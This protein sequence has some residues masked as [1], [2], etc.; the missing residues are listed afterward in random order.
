MTGWAAID[1]DGRIDAPSGCPMPNFYW[2][3]KD[4]IID[5]E[6]IANRYQVPGLVYRYLEPKTPHD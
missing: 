2:V 1:S 6:Q 3:A 4:E 5:F